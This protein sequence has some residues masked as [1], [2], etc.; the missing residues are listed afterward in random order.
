MGANLGFFAEDRERDFPELNKCPDC[1]T[2]FADAN[3]PL[4]GK[5]CPEE[6]RAGNRKPVK[7]KKYRRPSGNGRVQFVPWYHTV[8]FT[9]LMLILQ[10]IV[11]LILTWTGVWK[12]RWKVIV[13]V[14]LVLSHVLYY[15][16]GWLDSTFNPLNKVQPP[17]NLELTEVEYRGKCSKLDTET[18]YRQANAKIGE[19]VQVDFEVVE[20]GV[21]YYYTEDIE[22]VEADVYLCHTSNADKT[23]E[24]FIVDYRQENIIRLAVGDTVTV[25]GEV[26]GD[27]ESN[28]GKSGMSLKLPGI[29]ARFIDLK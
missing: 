8:W 10:P 1:E 22:Y 14:L 6:F 5:E 25:C 9:V 2:F 29:Y 17:I 13:T 12:T 24:F 4:C 16:Y 7:Q 15:G 26:A 23:L 28:A 3:C 21:T 27:I 11:G 20:V 19:Y 18:L